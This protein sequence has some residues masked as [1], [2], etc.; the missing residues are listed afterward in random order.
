MKHSFSCILAFRRGHPKVSILSW[1]RP[2]SLG[3]S[4]SSSRGGKISLKLRGTNVAYGSQNKSTN[5][6]QFSANIASYATNKW[7]DF[8]I[9]TRMDSSS[10]GFTK[11][12]VDGK[13]VLNYSGTNN[14]RGH[15]APYPKFGMYNGWRSRNIPNE[16]VTK[17]TLFHD[18]YRVA[19]GSAGSYNAVAPK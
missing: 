16:P 6:D 5:A 10:A 19:W 13:L 9:Q 7:V 4:P 8:V 2:C 17:R 3:L 11:I 15:G 18:E 1:V 14:F 12:W